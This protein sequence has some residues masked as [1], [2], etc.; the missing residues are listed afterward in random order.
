VFLVAALTT[1]AL[2]ATGLTSAVSSTAATN[3]SFVQQVSARGHAGSLGVTPG[4]AVTTGDRMVVEVGVWNSAGATASSVTD[5]AGNTYTELTHF[6]A[7]DNTE[8]SVWSAPITAGGGTKPTI[9]ASTTSAADIGIAAAEYA[10]LSTATGTSVLDVQAHATGK[11]TGA[12]TVASGATPPATT[13]NELAVGF[14]ADSGFGD[15]LTPGTGYASRVNMAPHPD[16]ELLIE[17][18]AAGQGTT[19]AATVGTGANTTW[20]MATLVF[21][22]A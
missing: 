11:T 5:T 10:G 14:Y 18:Q 15:T 7:S 1:T 13:G 19:P 2:A 17:D 16:M 8:M 22:H 3:P 4:S 21:N 20:L 9:T 6:K 12:A